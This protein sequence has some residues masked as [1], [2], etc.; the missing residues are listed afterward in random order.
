MRVG[1]GIL[2]KK[3][4]KNRSLRQDSGTNSEEEFQDED[5]QQNPV[6]AQENDNVQGGE[7]QGQKQTEDV[8]GEKNEPLD[9]EL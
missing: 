2:K 8:G 5:T 9:L 4:S 1:R 6:E 7:E 3:I